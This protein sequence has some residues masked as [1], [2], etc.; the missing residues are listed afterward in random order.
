MKQLLVHIG[1]IDGPMKY[2]PETL[3]AI[4]SGGTYRRSMPRVLGG[5]QGDGR[6]LM[7]EAPL[8]GTYKTVKVGF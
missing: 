1:R 6:F 7:S 4:R 3:A 5:S 8:Y 2:L